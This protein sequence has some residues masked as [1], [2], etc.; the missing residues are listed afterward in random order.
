MP[1]KPSNLTSSFSVNDAAN[2]VQCPLANQ[3]GSLCRKRCLGEKRYRSMQEH[4]RR[5]HPEYYLPKLPATK[6]SFELMITSPPHERPDIDPNHANHH[7]HHQHNVSQ[8]PDHSGLSPGF[9]DGDNGLGSNFGG[10]HNIGGHDGG[11]YTAQDADATAIYNNMHRPPDEYRRGSLIPTASAAQALAQL[12]SYRPDSSHG[13]GDDI[14]SG[15]VNFTAPFLLSSP[16]NTEADFLQ[17][18][19]GTYGDIKEEHPYPQLDPSLQDSTAY[20]NDQHG[21]P[22][23]T[24]QDDAGLLQTSMAGSPDRPTTMTAL[25]RTLSRGYSGPNRP[26]KSSLTSAR[27]GQHERK[28]SKDG[29]RISGDKKA[30]TDRNKRWEDLIDAAASATEEEGSRD[31]T[32]IP[33]SPHQSPHVTSRTSIPPMFGLGSQFGP[34]LNSSFQASPL[35]RALTPPSAD[36]PGLGLEHFTS[37]DSSISSHQHHHSTDSGSNF[38]IMNASSIDSSSPVFNNHANNVG[39]AS[40]VEVYCAGCRR[41]AFLV[42]CNACTNCICALC[43]SC[44][45]AIIDEQSRGRVAGCP[46]CQ[47]MDSSFKPFQVDLR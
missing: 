40:H 27:L 22:V 9:Y 8:H 5:A 24:S 28:R 12:S 32:P 2:E 30:L 1:P 34:Q 14:G 35:N 44:T 10:Y 41:P 7:N 29:K 37:V 46:R 18:A 6:E 47:V 38:H 11:Y 33:A 16:T 23:S 36:Q 43:Q 20:L 21:Y 25:H 19:Y 17:A 3:D 45:A 39:D 31:L 4:I 42:K 13:W 15:Q 26:R